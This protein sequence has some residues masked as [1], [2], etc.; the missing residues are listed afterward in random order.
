[1]ITG[2]Q[3]LADTQCMITDG[4]MNIHRH[5]MITDRGTYIYRYTMYDHGQARE[6]SDIQYI[7]TDRGIN[8]QTMYDYRQAHEY[9][10]TQ[11]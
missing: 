10:H 8:I 1:M 6:H 9:S 2:T 4:G 3:T 7:I 11:S 5:T